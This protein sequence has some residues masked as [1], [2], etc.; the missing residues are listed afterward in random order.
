MKRVKYAKDFK[1]NSCKKQAAVFV[2]LNDPDATD[3]PKCRK[4]ADEWKEKL[5][6]EI[7]ELSND[8]T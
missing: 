1:C 8:K 2:G 5:L 6:M 4:H 3:Y 7:S